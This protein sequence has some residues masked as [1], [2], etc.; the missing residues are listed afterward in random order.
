MAGKK[1]ERDLVEIWR[2]FVYALIKAK[3]LWGEFSEKAQGTSSLDNLP[4]DIQDVLARVNIWC[5]FENALDGMISFWA[6]QGGIEVFLIEEEAKQEEK[7][8]EDG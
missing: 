1:K 5:T 3:R 4:P 2:E 8:K 6:S 7:E